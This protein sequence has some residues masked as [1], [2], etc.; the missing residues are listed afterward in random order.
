VPGFESLLA[1]EVGYGVR[2]EADSDNAVEQSAKLKP[3]VVIAS[4][5]ATHWV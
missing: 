4:T 5:E 3:E 1:S 2:G